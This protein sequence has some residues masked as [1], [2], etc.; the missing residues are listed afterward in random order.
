MQFEQSF[1]ERLIQYDDLA[2]AQFYEQT[3]D[4]FFRY[5]ITHYS[6]STQ[7]AQDILSDVYLKIWNN[8]DKYDSKYKFWQFIWTILKNHC[9]D[10]FKTTRPLLFSE[11]KTTHEDG[12]LTNLSDT[13]LSEDNISDFFQTQFDKEIIQ[14]ALDQ[15]DESSQELIHSRYVL[16]Y[17]YETLSDMYGISNDTIRQKVSRIIK[18]L[19]N[20]L[21]NLQ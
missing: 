13:L 10:Y 14:N 12:S 1:V 7:E 19:R 21:K 20:N 3:V 17:S 5:I 4:Q 11:L 8:M 2:F 16:Q 9:K 6:L 18:K 15:L